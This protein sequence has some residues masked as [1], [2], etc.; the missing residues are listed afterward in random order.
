MED[1]AVPHTDAETLLGSPALGGPPAPPPQFDSDEYRAACN[2]SLEQTL[3][4]TTWDP[5]ENLLNLYSR[6][7]QEIA[8]AVEQ[9]ERV[10]SRI[11]EEVFPRIA[12]RPNAPAP[13]GVYQATPQQV[14]KV[15]R[16]LLFT[17]AVE[18]CDGTIAMHDT[19]PITIAQIGVC[20]VSYRGDQGSWLH[21][22]YRRDLRAAGLDPV[23]EALALLDRR[24]ARGA[25]GEP[26]KKDRL[27][28]LLSRG[29]MTYAERAVLLRKS[30]AMWRMGHGNPASYE[31]LTG[32]GNPDLLKHSLIL[33]E[34]LVFEH[35]KFVFVPSSTADRT[36]LTLGAALKPLEYIV[37]DDMRER[38]G[39]VAA[40]NYRG[41][42]WV[43]LA[44]D[45]K[46]FA[47][48]AGRKVMVGAYRASLLSPPQVFYAHENHVHEAALIAMADSALQEHR[49]FPMLI[50][51]ADTVCTTTFGGSTLD[52][53]TT[54]AYADAGAPFKHLPERTTRV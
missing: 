33:L 42:A 7:E 46:K 13:A 17:G 15:H 29:I 32:S 34:E 12:D 6:L 51:L 18:A 23:E 27:S 24:R 4:L 22:L 37:F 20:L 36:L 48:E 21:R 8:E 25:T 14:E 3:D 38:M 45:V 52:A 43:N 40:G 39:Q 9:E 2:E 5:G 50:D 30:N 31:L 28:S 1:S 26:S 54:V 41:E 49:G 11:R 47:A 10:R 19:L 35:K 53:A 16:G 44:N